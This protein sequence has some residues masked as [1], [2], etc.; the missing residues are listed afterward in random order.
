MTEFIVSER[1][2]DDMDEKIAYSIA[3]IIASGGSAKVVVTKKGAR[4]SLSQNA[5]QHSI[6]GEISRYLISKDRK[7][8]NPEWV[9]KMLKNKYLGWTQEAFTDVLTGEVT[10]REVLRSSSSLE[11]GEATIY[12]TQILEFADSIGC[13]I[14]IP[15]KCDYRDM[16]EIQNE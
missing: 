5:L 12:T 4:R 1:N 10:H 6:Y 2:I 9:K 3:E 8:C 13:E 15:A 11:V 7:D 14:K 16:M